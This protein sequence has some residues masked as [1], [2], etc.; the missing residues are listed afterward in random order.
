MTR[1]A[2]RWLVVQV[3]VSAFVLV[4]AA[5]Q[6]SARQ[7]PD[8]R[9]MSGMP[10]PVPD[11]SPGSVSVRLIKGSL[12]N[13]LAGQTV[14]LQG[15]SPVKALTN[16]QGRVEFANLQ[17][18]TRVKAVAVVAGER[19]ES[20]EFQVP[21]AGGIRLMLVATDPEAAKLAEAQRQAPAQPGTVVLGDQ[22][23]FVF[24]FNDDGLSVFNII[25]IVNSSATPVQPAEPLV[26]DL[27]DGAEGAAMLK[28]SSPQGTLAG[29]RVTVIG[30]F[31]PGI[32]LVQFAYSM[33]YSGDT[34]TVEQRLPVA[35]TQLTVL[36]QKVGETHVTSP[37]MAEHR[38]MASEGQT[39]IVGQG[40]ALAAGD[41]V[42]F[43][44]TGLPHT[45][46]WP[47]NV[48]LAAAALILLAGAWG[49]MRGVRISTGTA[50]RRKKLEGRRDRLF[51]E[52]T[53]LEEQH[54][55]GAA[56]AQHYAAR[57]RE[58]VTALEAVYA[59]LDEE[60]AA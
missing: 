9:Q 58:L 37:Q 41:V 52:L 18:G 34:L 33:S 13:P 44:F 17:P 3:A 38:E 14:E 53:S 36:A 21:A 4:G 10:L 16:D 5:T 28:E 24:E 50:Q 25:Q 39:Y 19:L 59:E 22:S 43:D 8:A 30:P 45:T 55:A 1:R 32:T 11:L 46:T 23:R 29:K 48:A 20:Q 2:I 56:D 15:P 42:R 31:A 35:M 49:G 26:F 54:R 47:R 57:R 27:P 7:M 40:P 6:S 51:A 12:S 60:A